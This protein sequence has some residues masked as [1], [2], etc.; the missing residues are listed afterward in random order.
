VPTNIKCTA[1][2]SSDDG[3]GWSE[4]HHIQG[5]DSP[6]PLLPFMQNFSALILNQRRPLLAKDRYCVGVRVAYRTADG[7]VASSANKYQPAV[8]PGN[9]RNG[10][11]PEVAAK[12]RFGEATNTQFSDVYLRGLWN[13]VQKNEELDFSAPPGDAWKQ[14]LDIYTTALIAGQYGWLGVDGATTRRGNI[15][16]YV[17]ETDGTITFT[18][19]GIVG[20]ALPSAGTK[21]PFRAARLNNSKSA[22]NRT[23]T[24]SVVNA[25]SVRTIQRFGALPFASA[26]TFVIAQTGFLKYTGTQY[27]V[28]ARRAAGAPFFHSPGPAPARATG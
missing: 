4:S 6:G 24:V 22:L 12:V 16:N 7:R 8:Y 23:M 25:T 17:E 10:D 11:A 9:Q 5:S 20:P 14:L 13:G 26:G 3:W 28:L 1:F 21:L 27:T 19:G 2:F 15:T 18:L